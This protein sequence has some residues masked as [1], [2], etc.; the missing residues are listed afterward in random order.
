MI[1]TT[2]N[3]VRG[4]AVNSLWQRNVTHYTDVLRRLT[5]RADGGAFRIA[6][7]SIP[8]QR[9]L[10]KPQRQGKHFSLVE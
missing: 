5:R 9:A 1:L 4:M 10:S 8:A 6:R 2:L 7:I 3:M